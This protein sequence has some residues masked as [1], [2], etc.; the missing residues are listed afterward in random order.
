MVDINIGEPPFP[1]SPVVPQTIEGDAVI[2]FRCHKGIDCFNA[3][4]R[5]IDISLTPYDVIRLKK[6]LGMTSGEFLVK[7]TYP[8]EMEKGGIAGIKLQ[9]VEGGTA[10]QFMTEE[11]C[12]VYE[13]RPTACRYYPVALL[14]LRRQDEYTDRTSYALVKEAHCHGHFE[15][16]KLTVDEYR[17]EQG[18]EEYDELGRGWRQLILKKKSSGPTVGKPSQRSLQLFFMACYDVDQFRE[19]IKSPSFDDVY[20]LDQ[21]TRDRLDDDVELMLFGQRF[22]AQVMFGE[23]FLAVRPDAYERRAAKKAEREARLDEIA[24]KIGP[25]PT[26]PPPNQDDPYRSG[27]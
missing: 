15:D 21:A 13:D 27:D 5:N 7:Y 4:C 20:E 17:K 3:C 24:E 19:F 12:S 14:S 9:P 1:G 10:C 26:T 6:R 2:Q 8:Y 22:L 11:G 18:L 16:R 25:L 23:T